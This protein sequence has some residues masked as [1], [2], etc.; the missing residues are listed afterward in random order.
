MVALPGF[1]LLKE[2]YIC[3]KA[4]IPVRKINIGLNLAFIVCIWAAS[5]FK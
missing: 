4:Y 1:Q 3:G 5:Y 2:T